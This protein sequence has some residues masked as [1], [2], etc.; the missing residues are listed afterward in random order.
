M[1]QPL[2]RVFVGFNT[3]DYSANPFQLDDPVYGLLDTGTLASTE[4]FDLT[5][6]VKSVSVNRGRSRQL[7]QF[8]AGTAVVQFDNSS[9]VLDPLNEDGPY[10]PF[11]LPR[12]P[13][14][15]TA[16]GIPIFYGLIVDW[17]LDYDKTGQDVMTAV[18]SDDFA[19]FANQVFDEFTPA[20]QLSGNR[21]LSVLA[22]AEVD[23]QG[24]RQVS[25]GS[26][27]LGAYA[28][29]AGTNVLNYLQLIAKSE[30]GFLYTSAN[31][32]FT[33]KGKDDTL[34]VNPD[35]FFS[36]DG[37]GIPY[38]SLSNQFGDELLYNYIVTES[39]AGG[40]FFA[41]DLDSQVKY[42]YQQLSLTDLLNSSSTDVEI[43]G[44]FLLNKYKEPLLRFTGLTNQLA[45]L[46]PT[47]QDV[48]LSIDLTDFCSV[49]K[50]FSNG[51]PSSITQDLFVSGV[52]HQIVPGSHIV[53]FSFEKAEKIVVFGA[54]S[55]EIVDGYRIVTWG[56]PG[57]LLLHDG[58][59]DVEYLVVGG[60]GGGGS[61]QIGQGGGGAGG[62]KTNVGGTLLTVAS[63]SYAVTVGAGGAG[64]GNGAAA[65]GSD[66]GGSS[67][68]SL[69]SVSGGGG[70]GRGSNSSTDA[71][72]LG[73]NG[74]SGGGAGSF[75]GTGGT[76]VSGEGF[77]G[78]DTA[79][80]SSTGG[81]GGGGAG[82]V[83]SAG[84]VSDGGN[85]GA[86][87]ANDISGTSVTYAGGGGGSRNAATGTNGLGGSGGGGDALNG[88][89]G[90]DG[91]DGLGGGGGAANGVSA[92]PRAGGKGGNG[93]VIVRWAV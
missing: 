71:L 40:P 66:G 25:T 32:V 6:L 41:S 68:G 42:Q 23:Y 70:G 14:R 39:P 43:I 65:Q 45:G 22:K 86:G 18:C 11:V 37:T 62:L 85:G 13:I 4:L 35:F 5:S 93:V 60:G 75:N 82:A 2:V 7:D 3:I 92:T 61:R 20:A 54:L 57:S 49:K 10:Y 59:L 16:N 89:D 74:G 63:G 17:N 12:V 64:G 72:R 79:N 44:D 73:R 38:Q 77:A 53:N 80:S 84:T 34:T 27:E 9:R 50:S 24:T 56:G 58:P 8:N 48:C 90:E 29:S 67:L 52:N 87:V 1:S 21:V 81:G 31:G 55:D 26:L 83:G 33:F 15:I 88:A 28:V 36:D 91:T 51:L 69:V 76:G 30:Q 19:V 46:S 78:G 47:D